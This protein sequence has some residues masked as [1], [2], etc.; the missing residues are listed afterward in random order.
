MRALLLAPVD[1]PDQREYL[2]A[3]ALLGTEAPE[4]WERKREKGAETRN[5]SPSAS[6]LGGARRRERKNPIP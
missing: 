5:N 2:C 6:A 4:L 1:S 3:K